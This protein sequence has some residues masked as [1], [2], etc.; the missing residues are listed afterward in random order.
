MKPFEPEPKLP[1]G[2]LQMYQAILEL[3]DRLGMLLQAVVEF[4]GAGLPRLA[5]DEAVV[6]GGE[7]FLHPFAET[8]GCAGLL[9][10]ELFQTAPQ[11]GYGILQAVDAPHGFRGSP[12]GRGGSTALAPGWL[13]HREA[14]GQAKQDRNQ[15]SM[16][17]D[18][19]RTN[20]PTLNIL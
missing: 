13:A 9:G 8:T 16:Q 15:S 6:H 14:D 1:I 20:R 12:R 11:I 10:S 3:L 7:P 2:P 4:P 5:L 17:H 19:R 18:S